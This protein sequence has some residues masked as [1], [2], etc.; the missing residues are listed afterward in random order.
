MKPILNKIK[1]RIGC[2]PATKK[3]SKGSATQ[4]KGWAMEKIAE[5]H[6]QN[7]G[8]ELLERNFH[9]RY[10]EID[11]ICR[12]KTSL[13]FVE[14]KYRKNNSQLSPL[15]SVTLSKQKK[16]SQ[17]AQYYLIKNPQYAQ[18]ICRFD[19][20]GLQ[21]QEKNDELTIEWVRNAFYAV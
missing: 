8:L 6:L 18:W 16:L 21:T 12:D 5:S 4:R 3:E 10:G 7:A 20:V 17:A 11:L 13:V 1:Q 19:V 9:C 15:E 14:V 2:T